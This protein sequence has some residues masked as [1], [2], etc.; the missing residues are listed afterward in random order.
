MRP[1]DIQKIRNAQP[2]QPFRMVFT[3]GRVFDIPHPDHLFIA[4]NTIEIGV[5][6]NEKTRIPAETVHAWPLYVVRIEILDPARSQ[7]A[8]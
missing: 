3:D 6:P 1:E 7:R 4:Q 8:P 2:F 5:E